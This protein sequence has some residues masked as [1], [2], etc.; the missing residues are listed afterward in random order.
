[1]NNRLLSLSFFIFQ[2]L[3]LLSQTQGIKHEQNHV[4]DQNVKTLKKKI[5]LE[6]LKNFRDQMFF[7][8]ALCLVKKEKNG[9]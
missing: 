2:H 3:S 4:L 1:V 8:K 6:K 5:K 9:L 7:K